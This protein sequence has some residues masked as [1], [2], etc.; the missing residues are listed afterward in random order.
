MTTANSGRPLGVAPLNGVRHTMD[1]RSIPSSPSAGTGK[2]HVLALVLM[3]WGI[4]TCKRPDYFHKQ[5][6]TLAFGHHISLG[7]L[8]S[9]LRF[10][11]SQD[12]AP[13]RGRSDV[14]D[15]SR[16]LKVRIRHPAWGRSNRDVTD[17]TLRS[18]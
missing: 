16:F 13:C 18:D 5:F 6:F 11:F 7:P 10:E 12:V 1:R 15:L 8:L 2:V 4:P 9:D 17:L 3:V 14:T